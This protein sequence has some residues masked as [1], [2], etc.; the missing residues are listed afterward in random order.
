M[1]GEVNAVVSALRVFE[2]PVIRAYPGQIMEIPTQPMAAVSLFKVVPGQV[3]VQV[4][5]TAPAALGGA[6]CENATIKA[7]RILQNLGVHGAFCDIRLPGRMRKA[8]RHVP[9][10]CCLFLF[11][12]CFV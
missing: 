12:F 8:L 9:E 1:N 11:F 2:Y 10:G 3:T 5:M 6:A 4:T 7:G